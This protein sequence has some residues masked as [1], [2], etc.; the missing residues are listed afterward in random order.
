NPRKLGRP[1]RSVRLVDQRREPALTLAVAHECVFR[2]LQ[3]A[4]HG[5]LVRKQRGVCP[6]LGGIDLSTHPP[7]IERR[8]AER[9]GALPGATCGFAELTGISGDEAEESAQGDL[10]KQV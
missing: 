8:P 10:R 7:K 3:R 2:F 4:Q 1:P 6:G 9:G 5:L